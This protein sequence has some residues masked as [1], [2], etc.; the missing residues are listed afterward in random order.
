MPR[1]QINLEP[2]RD[3]IVILYHGGN[4]SDSIS[5]TLASR[6]NIQVKERT[7]QSRLRKWGI[8]KRHR[9]TTGDEALHARIKMLYLQDRLTDKAML[10]MLQQEGYG[11]SER[12]LRRLR[13]K[14]G[15][16]A[17]TLDQEQ[18]QV[19]GQMQMMAPLS[20]TDTQQV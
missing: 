10:N 12:T 9:T 8:R 7:I 15:L 16:H 18:H 5:R 3:E 6:H 17:R 1:H 11:I 13:F 2:Y 20:Q 19:Q 4:S 14:L